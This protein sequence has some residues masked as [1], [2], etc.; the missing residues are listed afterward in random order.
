MEPITSVVGYAARRMVSRDV[1]RKGDL[2]DGIF[3][4]L[5][6]VPFALLVLG[7]VG[8]GGSF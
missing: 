5:E 4:V 8:E 3:V 7:V 6:E 2:L 1:G